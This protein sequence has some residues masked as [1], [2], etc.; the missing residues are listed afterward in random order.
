M[1]CWTVLKPLMIATALLCLSVSSSTLA[2]QDK[3]GN[4]I[5][6]SIK[7]NASIDQGA[8]DIGLDAYLYFY[9]LV[10]MDITRRQLTNGNNE[11]LGIA[12]MNTFRHARTFPPA[13]FKTVV[14]PNFDTLYS[15]AWLNLTDGPVI[16]S[17]PDTNG[18]YYLLPMIDMWTDVFASPGKRTTGTGAEDF[19]IVPQGWNG[20]LPSGVA[21]IDS[22]TPYVWIIGRT[23][24][25]VR[26]TTKQF[27]KYRTAIRSRLS[28]SGTK[29]R[30]R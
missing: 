27:I 7:D 15:I 17:A 16:V 22:P 20:I 25:T 4:A 3:V 10:T 14:R 28:P 21:R 24:P 29:I 9:P 13:D 2:Q 18:R 30:N 12:P 11:T 6:N 8:Y 26:A 23:R 1:K 19:A 5:T